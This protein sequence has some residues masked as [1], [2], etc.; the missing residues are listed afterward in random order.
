MCQQVIILAKR[1][2]WRYISQ[3]EH[4]TV[5]LVWDCVGLHL[6]AGAFVELALRIQE[7]YL[8]LKTNPDATGHGRCRLQVS[9]LAVEL[10]L[11]DFVMLAGMVSEAMPHIDL[12]ATDRPCS[13]LQLTFPQL[14]SMPILN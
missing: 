5:H 7:V 13:V 12:Y 6:A 2:G 4:G 3:C 8:E 10:P 9:R 11:Q 1:A 14:N